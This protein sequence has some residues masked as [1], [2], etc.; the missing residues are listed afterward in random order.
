MEEKKVSKLD[1]ITLSEYVIAIECNCGKY[2]QK[3]KVGCEEMC[4]AARII[5]NDRH[6]PLS[7]LWRQVF[8]S[9]K[10]DSDKAQRRFLQMPIVSIQLKSGPCIL[11]EKRRDG[12]YRETEE[13][14]TRTFGSSKAGEKT[15][16]SYDEFK[17]FVDVLPCNMEVQRTKH[18]FASTHN[19][20]KRE[21]SKY[22]IYNISGRAEKIVHATEE[23]NLIFT[24]QYNTIYSAK[25]K[26]KI[27][28]QSFRL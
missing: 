19:L 23:I 26:K 27:N 9:I 25:E 6:V 28:L 18:L 14:I 17:L 20:S 7:V 22:G 3:C 21:G 11:A 1:G 5:M 15:G 4:K 16:T 8:P 24:I 12:D 10:Y 2:H 13:E